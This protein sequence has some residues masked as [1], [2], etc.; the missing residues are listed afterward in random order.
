MNS[1]IPQVKFIR[2]TSDYTVYK[3]KVIKKAIPV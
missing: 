2:T 1:L 3:Q